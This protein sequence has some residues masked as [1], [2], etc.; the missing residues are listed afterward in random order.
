MLIAAVREVVRAAPD[1]AAIVT[2]DRALTYAQL[3]ARAEAMAGGLAAR[4]LTRFGVVTSDWSDAITV[5]VAASLIGAEP[6]V[7]P[8]GHDDVERA[9]LAER[10]EHQAV[11]TDDDLA[12]LEASTA[13]DGGD[14]GDGPA[15]ASVMILTTGTTGPPKGARHQWG[16]LLAG[17]RR[18]VR[19]DAHWLLAYNLNQFAG[20][21]VLLH[22]I[23]NAG[24]LVLPPTNRPR[25]ALA[26]MRTH[27]V[28]HA[29]AT[30]TFWRFLTA[31]LGDGG[32]TPAL[33]QVTLGGEAI[34]PGLVDELT[35]WF[36]AAKISQ[37]YA[38]TEF[39]S[40]VS[41]RD[42]R[43]GL[44]VDVLE[45]DEDADVQFRIVDGELYARSKVGMLGYYG[46][47]RADPEGWRPT[48]DVVEVVGDRILFA[49][50]T[51][52]VINVGGVKVHP[53]RVEEVVST[54][55]GVEL[56]K[57]SGRKNALT[58]QIVSVEVV[59]KQGVDEDDLEDAIR[60][61]C[62][63]LPEAARPRRIKFVEALA[64]V[65]NK[66]SRRTEGEA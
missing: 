34:P 58:G 28:T 50:R 60:A 54:V 39:G 12:A 55:P 36:P 51:S 18:G 42:D 48:G 59:A 20:M 52:E 40:A 26:A 23:A 7:Y 19:P 3:N 33:E 22:S 4:G 17:V 49:G 35:R 43:I 57:A 62:E 2:N 14:D 32:P 64:V 10:F 21:Q 13:H 24:A 27:G 45:R 29:S 38:S 15:D 46:D 16:R 6:C 5:L 61:A 44:P 1:Q 31:I 8:G 63:V 11:I 37:I 9:A 53:L 65:E 66:I 41:V 47:D 30:P 56:V 25:D